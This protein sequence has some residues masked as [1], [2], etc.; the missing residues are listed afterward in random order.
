[1][2]SHTV[3]PLP[4]VYPLVRLDSISG[5][6]KVNSRYTAY[7]YGGIYAYT[8]WANHS[9]ATKDFPR[10]IGQSF[11][12]SDQTVDRSARATS[13]CM[14]GASDDNNHRDIQRFEV[15]DVRRG[16]LLKHAGDTIRKESG[17]S[18]PS[19]LKTTGDNA[20]VSKSFS[21]G[22]LGLPPS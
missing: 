13:L 3:K 4:C 12:I 9:Q 5:M 1:M 19:L 20:Y 15:R 6:G 7:Y 8:Q 21:P 2:F 16:P 18:I 17:T 11:A 14:T 10:T 22:R